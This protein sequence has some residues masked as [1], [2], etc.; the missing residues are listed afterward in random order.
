[1]H[2]IQVELLSSESFSEFG[3]VIAVPNSEPTKQGDGWRCWNYIS[4]MSVD[5]D[6]GLGIVETS[7]R[8]YEIELME[9]HDQREEMLLAVEGDII[10]PVATYE[11]LVDGNEKPKIDRVRCFLIKK[12]QGIILR[13]GI[14]HSPAF[15]VKGDTNYLFAIEKKPDI[16]HDEIASPWI[17]FENNSKVKFKV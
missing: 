3:T 10:Q 2:T 12:G 4:M 17:A 8:P 7:T 6:I 14:W 1:M 9:R 16:H 15:P 11:T 13:K 5:T